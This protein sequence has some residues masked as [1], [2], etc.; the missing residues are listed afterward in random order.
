MDSF[1]TMQN[2][3]R[4]TYRTIGHPAAYGGLDKLQEATGATAGDIREFAE[5]EDIYQKF[6]P[7]RKRFPRAQMRYEPYNVL[8]ACDTVN[9]KSLAPYNQNKGYWLMV[10]ETLS[11][12]LSIELLETLKGSEIARAFQKIV[13]KRGKPCK[14]L[15]GDFGTEFFSPAMKK[16][17][18]YY[19]INLYATGNETKSFLGNEFVC[20]Y[21]E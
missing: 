4:K 10:M 8:W 3:L 7:A 2:R 14:F 21:F 1:L 20:Y 12:Q 13:V 17:C 15:M 18:R 19:R 5:T 11:R 16:L 9:L 6:K